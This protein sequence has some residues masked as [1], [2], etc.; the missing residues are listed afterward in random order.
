M[1]RI[2]LV[3]SRG[4]PRE[5]AEMVV[6][7]TVRAEL[8]AVHAGRSSRRMTRLADE[9]AVFAFE[10]KARLVMVEFS[11]LESLPARGSMAPFARCSESS[12]VGIGMTVA[13]TPEGSDGE[14]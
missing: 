9:S 7:V 4:S 11:S 5:L 13:A 3:A 8:E 12:F 14:L 2:A 6:L 10:S 1:A